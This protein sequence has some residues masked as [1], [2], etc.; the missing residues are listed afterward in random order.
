MP[1]CDLQIS[2]IQY[3]W[4]DYSIDATTNGASI[5]AGNISLLKDNN[6]LPTTPHS[7]RSKCGSITSSEI[8]VTPCILAPKAS[9]GGVTIRDVDQTIG[10]MEL[11]NLPAGCAMPMCTL[12]YDQSSDTWI[13]YSVLAGVRTGALLVNG[14]FKLNFTN[15]L[16][17][18]AHKF[19]TKCDTGAYEQVSPE[20]S[21]SFEECI[22]SAK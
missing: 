12:E 19:R 5:A 6:Y 2:K 17:T 18:T 9:H 21:V 1:S 16:P 20:V 22:L 14:G 7:L 4:V 8:L 15:Y 10:G 11:Y 13:E 3:T